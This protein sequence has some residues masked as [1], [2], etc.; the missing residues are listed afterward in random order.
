MTARGV[1][2][3]VAVALAV[4]LLALLGGLAGVASAWAVPIGVAV[5]VL[6][7]PP[8]APRALTTLGGGI[9]ALV[10]HAA[11][12]GA[13]DAEVVGAAVAVTVLM[14]AAGLLAQRDDPRTPSWA[15]LVG[16]ATVLAG[17]QVAGAHAL[18][19]VA[20]ALGGLIVGILPMQVGEIVGQLRRRRDDRA[21]LTGLH[22][23]SGSADAAPAEGPPAE[24]DRADTDPAG[25][26]DAETTTGERR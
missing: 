1:G 2:R 9:V 21:T 3:I 24:G 22:A 6:G 16:G 26:A 10:V 14:V 18:G 7:R 15:V 8:V 23:P 25:T 19:D 11:V 12:T 4:G 17:A 5:S 13:T 20:P